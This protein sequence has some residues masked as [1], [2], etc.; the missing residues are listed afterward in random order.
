MP[1]SDRLSKRD[2]ATSA[3]PEIERRRLSSMDM[4]VYA[5]STMV[6]HLN[7]MRTD[8]LD[9]GETDCVAASEA[10][11]LAIHQILG[12]DSAG[13]YWFTRVSQRFAG[14]TVDVVL[15]AYSKARD[16]VWNIYGA[17]QGADH[18]P[19]CCI[20]VAMCRCAGVIWA[21]GYVCDQAMQDA[22]AKA[23]AE[24]RKVSPHKTVP[25]LTH[26]DVGY[27]W[28][29]ICAKC[30]VIARVPE[31]NTVTANGLAKTHE[32]TALAGDTNRHVSP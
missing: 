6:S 3:L 26:V 4:Y 9:D 10:T 1:I 17:H 29:I 31:R 27:E 8:L 2:S 20:C 16:I 13:D 25:V 23:A 7:L 30:G 18:H 21:V 22:K 28:Q 12:T 24:S 5:V 11:F 32:R 15:A 14:S 19:D